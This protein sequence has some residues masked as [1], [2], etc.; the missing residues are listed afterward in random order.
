MC[1]D[2]RAIAML[3]PP[4]PLELIAIAKAEATAVAVGPPATNAAATARLTASEAAP[5]SENKNTV[6]YVITLA[7]LSS[8]RKKQR[9]PFQNSSH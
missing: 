8:V 2:I 4:Q 9:V 1:W 7:T 3:K 6:P 5:P